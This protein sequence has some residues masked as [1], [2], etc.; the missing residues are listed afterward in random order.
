MPIHITCHS[1]SDVIPWLDAV[2]RLR[3]TVFRDYPYLYDGDL[4]YEREYLSS[5]AASPFSLFVLAMDDQEVVGAST[6][7]AL[8]DADPAFQLPFQQHGISLQD[9]LYFGESVLNPVYRGQGIGHRF[10]DERERFAQQHGKQVTAFCAIERPDNHPR[11]PPDYTPLDAFWLQRGYQQHTNMR[12]TYN[13]LDI[14]H[15][16]ATP[17]PMVFWL[18]QETLT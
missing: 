5:Y 2:A 16:V 18:R 1:G 3:I 7:I 11:R 12:T 17:K 14:D 4:D 15:A 8:T 6:A 13:W 9:V 10:F